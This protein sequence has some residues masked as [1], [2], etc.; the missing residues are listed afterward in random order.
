MSLTPNK[1]T[2]SPLLLEALKWAAKHLA[3]N[4]IDQP[5]AESERLLALAM[6]SDRQMVMRAGNQPLDKNVWQHFQDYCGRRA[7]HEPFAYISG[8]KEFYGRNF[9]VDKHVLIPRP[10]TELLVETVIDHCQQ[11]ACNVLEL[12]V[13]SGAI[14]VSVL[15][16]LNNARIIASDASSNALAIA[17]T[18]AKQL[19]PTERQ[20]RLTL[21][22]S[23]QGS[24]IN[25]EIIDQAPYDVIVSNPPYIA[26]SA[27]DSLQSEVANYEPRQALD[28][29]N[30]GHELMLSWI[31]ETRLLLSQRGTMAMEFSPEQA[32]ILKQTLPP[33]F[34]KVTIHHDLAGLARYFVACQPQTN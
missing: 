28:G 18:N 17:E 34:A 24:S 23:Q 1:T 14:A 8:H 11:A 30:L 4:G 15:A 16:E 32:N 7:K 29:G 13:G 27:I 21:A 31:M 22:K 5:Q 19:L 25:Q 12:G 20:R 33:L 26:S 10:E 3:K 6:K 2:N 9:I